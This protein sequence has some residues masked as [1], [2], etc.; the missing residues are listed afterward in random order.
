MPQQINLCTPILLAPKRYFSATTM[1]QTLAVFAIFGGGLCA[2]WVWNLERARQGVEQTMVSQ[3]QEIESL[4]A[5]IQRS[6]DRAL[7]PEPA[8][9][10][11][12]QDRRSAVLAKEKVLEALQQG[13]FAPGEGH[14]DRLALVSRSIPG[15][16]WVT[17]IRAD[18]IRFEV[19]GFTLEPSALNQWVDRLSASP[20]MRGLK[21]A[22]VKVQS[23]TNRAVGTAASAAAPASSSVAGREAWSFNLVSAQP[24]APPLPPT[25]GGKP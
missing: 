6:K 10:Q 5:A 2:A 14:S 9:L 11:Q 25:S 24:V 17:D 12:Q 13:L 15:P 8:L 3:R 16:I 18:E 19:S 4:Q 1:A 20:L 22:T 21:L 23:A 7:P